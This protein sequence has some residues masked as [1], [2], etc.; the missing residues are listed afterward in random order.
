MARGKQI[1]HRGTLLLVL[2]TLL[3]VG[4]DLRFVMASE[5]Q[6][7]IPTAPVDGWEVEGMHGDI[8]VEGSLTESPCRLKMES[9]EQSVSLGTIPRYRLLRIGD[10]SPVVTVHLQ[11]EDC[12]MASNH[13]RNDLYEESD[14]QLPDQLVSFLTVEG[15]E[16][17][18]NLHLLKIN[19]DVEGVALRL[20]DPEHHQLIPG[21]HS[22]GLIMKQGNTDLVLYAMLERT[23]QPL[24]EGQFNVLMNFTLG[25]H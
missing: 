11:L 21:E 16:S 22:R 4:S 7:S 9:A 23:E 12:G 5:R 3:I 20:E 18:D 13:L 8:H 10:H 17:P 19:G 1:Y 15:V 25:Y 14:Y 24:K 2:V 6:S